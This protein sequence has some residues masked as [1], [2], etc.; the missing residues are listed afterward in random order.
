LRAGSLQSACPTTD[1]PPRCGCSARSGECP[2]SI[3][4][5]AP[6]ER[7]QRL[8]RP[9]QRLLRSLYRRSRHSSP[10]LSEGLKN[11]ESAWY[12]ALGCGL[13]RGARTLALID[14]SGRMRSIRRRATIHRP[15]AW[16]PDPLPRPCAT[17]D[18]V[19][20]SVKLSGRSQD[21]TMSVGHAPH[22]PATKQ[23]DMCRFN[24]TSHT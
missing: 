1:I 11:P 12:G 2:G 22:R 4:M 14:S 9:Q 20:A 17:R 3:D 21:W 5:W 19:E 7:V 16:S 18:I 24:S 23:L 8:D 6:L 13:W 10:L 15:A